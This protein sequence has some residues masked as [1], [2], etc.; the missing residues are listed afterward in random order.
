MER[1]MRRWLTFTVDGAQC[2]ATL[3]DA[4]GTHGLLIVSGG[5]ET[6][7]GAHRGMA[8]LAATLAAAGHPVFRFDRRGVGD[9]AGE[10]QG[11]EGSAAD[12]AGAIAAFRAACP[13]VTRITAFGNC[14]GAAALA[15]HHGAP[16][17]GAPT[18][19]APA[20]GAPTKGAPAADAPRP[21][22]HMPDALIIANPWTIDARPPADSPGADGGDAGAQMPG[23]SSPAS[24]PA[25]P[26]LPPAAAIRARDLAK[27]KNPKEVWRLISGGVDLRKLLHGV[28]AARRGNGAAAGDP[29]ALATRLGHA[30]GAITDRPVTI[31]IAQ[32]DGTAQA[33]MAVW[34]TAP[35]AAA[36]RH[37][38]LLQCNTP[39]HSFA[40]DDSKA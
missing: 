40:D 35:Y 12:I 34:P 9:S 22:A 8:M 2:A 23:T 20:Q 33:F 30:L 25:Q 15:L 3:D 36:R 1:A 16:A 39:S 24:A 37:A 17:E 7:A 26:A 32:G 13:H 5:N 4:A 27:L 19:S 11:F 6:R 29:A 31:L 14:D 38:R 10:N 21:D 28:M 18:K